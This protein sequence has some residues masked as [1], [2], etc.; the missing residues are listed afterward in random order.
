MRNVAYRVPLTLISTARPFEEEGST[1]YLLKDR[2]RAKRVNVW[3]VVM[4]VYRGDDYVRYVI[5]DFT[6]VTRATVFGEAP[7]V[8]VGDTVA[9][10][11]RLSARGD[12]VGI[13][14][15]NVRKME[16]GEEIVKRLD[17]MLT[18]KRILR[19]EPEEIRAPA[20]VTQ[21]VGE[22]VEEM[23]VETLDLE[24]E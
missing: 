15:E 9:V 2:L 8:D 3:G 10:V 7:D 24:E 4:G 21:D 17:N 13:I 11:G 5:D 23:E 1:Q 6:G 12:E 14:V 22:S 19:M 20:P 18:L 16:Q